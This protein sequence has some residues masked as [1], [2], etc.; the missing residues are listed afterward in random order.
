ME[1]AARDYTVEDHAF[2]LYRRARGAADPLPPAFRRAWDIDAIDHVRML[3]ALTRFVDA[4]IS[5]TVNV[6]AD[7]P[8]DEYQA[9][10]LA[11]WQLGLK[12]IATFRPNPVSGAVLMEE[13]G[14]AGAGQCGTA[15]C[16]R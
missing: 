6:P 13:E 12:G 5:K 4:G 2:R 11:A 10:Y 14:E 3:A 9:L 1:G 16:T 7:C 15:R 8:F